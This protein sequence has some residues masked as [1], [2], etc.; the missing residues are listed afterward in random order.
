MQAGEHGT[1]QQLQVLHGIFNIYQAT[2]AVF[3]VHGAR[4]HQCVDLALPELHSCLQVKRYNTVDKSI[5]LGFD[6]LPDGGIPSY[7]PQFDER[8][9]LKRCGLTAGTI[10]C[11]KGLQAGSQGTFRAKGAQAQVELKSP[12]VTCHHEIKEL[13]HEQFGIVTHSHRVW[14]IGLPLPA[15]DTEDFQVGRIPQFPSTELAK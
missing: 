10:I 14:T 11:P 2:P 6:G 4:R 8:L 5:A 3:G 9:A 1:V 7:P 15:V 12:S 13:L